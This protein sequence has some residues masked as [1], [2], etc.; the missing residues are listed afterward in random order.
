MTRPALSVP[1]NTRPC[2]QPVPRY[3]R[4]VWRCARALLVLGGL[5]CA[6]LAAAQTVFGAQSPQ[7]TDPMAP[8]S[9]MP[10]PQP[11]LPLTA[12][13]LS[14]VPAMPV[15]ALPAFPG[16]PMPGMP[17]GPEPL[18]MP[19]MPQAFALP[20]ITPAPLEGEGIVTGVDS[21][22]LPPAPVATPVVPAIEAHARW[23]DKLTGQTSDLWLQPDTAVMREHL[24]I[25]MSECRVPAAAPASDA[26]A[27]LVIIDTRT[28][29]QLFA[30]WMVASSP[31]LSAMDHPRHDVWLMG[32][33]TASASG[34]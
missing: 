2:G 21:P 32:C 34:Q 24:L 10:A 8:L 23:L 18:A 20:P 3:G 1:P 25:V 4:G 6:D 28:D 12:L 26:F 7:Q 14:S 17:D 27:Y 16:F 22:D 13:P 30:G 5:V 9:V 15:P 31:A 29:Q 33:N 11:G 19:A